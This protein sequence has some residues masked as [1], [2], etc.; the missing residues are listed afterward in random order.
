MQ[1]LLR[2]GQWLVRVWRSG[3][4][5]KVGIGMAGLILLGAISAR[6]S[7]SAGPAMP[8]PTPI[9]LG[10]IA[11]AAPTRPAPAPPPQPSA[12]PRPTRAPEPTA[13]ARPTSLPT[14]VP[15]SATPTPS[16]TL[17][18]GAAVN[19][20]TGPSAAFNKVRTLDAAEPVTIEAR[21]SFQEVVWY[22]VRT[23]QGEVGWISSEV[24]ALDA[25]LVASLPVST[26]SFTLPT[27][28][29][30]RAP[31]VPAAPPAAAA[32]Q[33]RYDPFGPDRD[34][35]D[36][37]SYAQA[38]AFFVAAG[39]PSRDPHRLDGDNDGIPCESLR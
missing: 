12:G 4:R 17:A 30:Q 34:C 25:A 6:P 7:Q 21:Q 5:G 33:V 35:G 39:G 11:V 15:P 24:T 16:H 3:I 10:L 32:P 27:A 29:A 14:N 38:Y 22:Q 23:S 9:P 20:R 19:V 8:S 37:A 26:E 28:S 1:A 18:L 13:T 2:F 36:F 31:R